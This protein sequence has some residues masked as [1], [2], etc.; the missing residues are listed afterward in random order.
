MKQLFFATIAVMISLQV[1]AQENT[2]Y[3][4]EFRAIYGETLTFT[5][6]NLLGIAITD[7]LSGMK[8]DMKTYGSYGIGYR[9]EHNRLGIGA[10]ISYIGLRNDVKLAAGNPTD[11]RLNENYFIVLPSADFTYFK[12][13]IFKLYGGVGLGAMVGI[14]NQKSLTTDGGDYLKNNKLDKNGA[15]LA[16][17]INPLGVRIGSERIGAFVEAGYGVKGLVNVGLSLKF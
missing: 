5:T 3:K 10:D 7:A 17:Q 8:T 11:F 4:H 1:L 12:S 13:G 9:Y 2:A 14:K 15:Y 16:Y 6:A